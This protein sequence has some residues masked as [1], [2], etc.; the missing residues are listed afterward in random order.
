MTASSF[1]GLNAWGV[2]L[3]AAAV[4]VLLFTPQLAAVSRE[5]R[6]AADW[7]YL[8]GIRAVVDS[9]HPGVSVILSYGLA[10]ISDSVRLSGQ[11]VSCFDGNGTLSMPVA[12]RLP[13]VSLAAGAHYR[14][15]LAQGVVE[16][17][18]SV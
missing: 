5:S 11:S 12:W 9:L 4:L 8:D 7:R 18:R 10:G 2:Y 15:S 1:G 14:L 3:F 16:V 13:N 6:E 17:E